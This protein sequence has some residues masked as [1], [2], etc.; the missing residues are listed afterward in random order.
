LVE[1]LRD[2]GKSNQRFKAFNE[3]CE[4]VMEQEN[5]RQAWMEQLRV[6]ADEITELRI[7]ANCKCE[8]ERC[9]AAEWEVDAKRLQADLTCR[10]EQYRQAVALIQVQREEIAA[11]DTYIERLQTAIEDALSYPD[12]DETMCP[13]CE[14]VDA[15][16]VRK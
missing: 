4:L 15:L 10:S 12:V 16:E 9:D 2:A 5:E 11:K 14:M 7:I 1:L 3:M 13:W 8:A 6:L